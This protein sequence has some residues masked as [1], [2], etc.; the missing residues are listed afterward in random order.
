MS[1]EADKSF[2]PLVVIATACYKLLPTRGYFFNSREQF[3][4]T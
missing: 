4:Y 2:D 3:S 1:P